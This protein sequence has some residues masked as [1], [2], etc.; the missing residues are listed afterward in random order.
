[1]V[2]RL[3]EIVVDCHDPQALAGFW[4]AALGYDVVRSQAD[5]VEIA[6]W[7]REP[8]DLAEQYRQAP[9]VTSIVFVTVPE[10]KTVKNRVHLDV[11][12][13]DGDIDTEVRRLL[14]LGARPADIGQNAVPWTV[15]QD[16][17]GNEFCVLRPLTG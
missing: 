6:P 11:R 9:G 7:E 15:L 4:S 5:E 12:P 3:T 10:S 2:L 1:M 17:E 8:D 14:D 13:V 16:P